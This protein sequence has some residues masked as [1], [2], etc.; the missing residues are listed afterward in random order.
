VAWRSSHP[1]SRA[2]WG[3]WVLGLVLVV[4]AALRF[5]G[6]NWDAGHWL[7]PDERQIYFIALDLD[8]PAS[9]AEALS[10]E[11]PLNPRFFAYGS[12]PIYLVRL[13]AALLAPLWPA[14]HD[15]DNLHLAGRLLA[16]AF[17]LGTV[18]L[19]YRLARQLATHPRRP[20]RG[21]EPGKG[22]AGSRQPGA[23]PARWIPLLIAALVSL[24]VLHIQLA[25]FYTADPLLAF[26][27]MLTLSLAFDVARDTGRWHRVGLGLALGLAL[28]TK[29]SAAPL[30]L[31]PLVAHYYAP[32]RAQA[33]A[34]RS[35]LQPWVILQRT[36]V[37]LLTAAAVFF[38]TQ[39][40]V[41]IDWPT[42]V[43][44]TLRE[45]QIAWGRLD[46]P[47]T[48]QYA[49]TWPYFYQAWQVALW[50]LALP[51][52]LAAWTGLMVLIVGW[53]RRG[54]W[55]A[56]LILAWAGIYFA[57]TGL[58]YAKPLRYMLPLVPV[59]CTL[60]GYLPLRLGWR[61]GGERARQRL[62][63][64][65]AM[66]GYGTFVAGSLI[67]ALLYVQ[68]Y[69]EPHSWSTA[70][71]W[72]YR[73]VP[74]G[75]TLAVEHW[76]TPLPLPLEVDGRARRIEEYDTRV[77]ALYDEPDDG[78]KWEQLAA[79]LAESDYLIIASRRLYGSIE[80]LP[81]R[82]PLASRYYQQLFA[83][84]LGFELAGEFVRGPEWLNPRV[85]PLPG[86]A[87]TLL[88]PDESFVV[89]DHPRTLVFRNT[90]RM[91]AEELLGCVGVSPGASLGLSPCVG[92]KDREWE[93]LAVAKP[94][95]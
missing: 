51:V 95:H 57:V 6:L 25:H 63:G 72:I 36:A 58:L 82:Y 70:S 45:S 79:D 20:E 68:I 8:W 61:R 7:Q 77:L 12:L 18:Y 33:L 9:L 71:A 59:L 23:E 66:A 34:G 76:D 56:A 47:Y 41:L 32:A 42:F 13:F 40:Y 74:A 69:A 94:S 84:E 54:G 87:P 90:G 28:A 91:S 49:G 64:R 52:G 30:A 26:F 1:R 10:P 2:F 24:A 15:P 89:Y 78:K 92:S 85:P 53:L 48:L 38:L 62:W 75:S 39:P 4:G 43:G 60:V 29:V 81:D 35:P 16:V 31:V 21:E 55:A 3:P 22:E 44:H 46:V 86:A 83:G 19:S 50:G 80:G 73:H 67:Y 11:S 65:L 14:V 88:R 27:V 37:T 17:E 5:Y 93:G